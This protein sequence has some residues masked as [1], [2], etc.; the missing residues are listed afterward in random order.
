[1]LPLLAAPPAGTGMNPARLEKIRTRMQEFADRGKA[2][3]YVTLIERHGLIATLD[4]VGYQDLESKTPMRTDTIFQMMSMTKSLTCAGILI[5]M[6]EGRL[7]VVDAVEKHLPEFQGQR[8]EVCPQGA[9]CELLKP[10]RPIRI[11]DLMTHTSGMPG[12]APPEIGDTHHMTLAEAVSAYAKLPLGFEAGAKWRYSNTGIATLGRIIEVVSGI[13]YEKFIAQRI[14][15]P[16]G[17]QDSFYFPPADKRSRIAA[18]Y[19]EEN[20]KLKRAAGDIYREG[21]K[22]PMPEGG[23]YS[24]AS[25]M[26]AYYQM[27]LSGGAS[28]GGRVLSKYSV[29]LMTQVETGDL[30]VTFAPGLGYGYGLGVVKDPPGMFRLSSLGSFGHGGAYRTY[31]WVDPAKDM[32]SVI[33]LQRTNGGGDVADEINAFLAMAAAA[34]ER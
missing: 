17:M 15:K 5:L 31:G 22:Y 10:A 25:D 12:G 7:S 30:S 16:L 1:M 18:V 32:V 28:K 24:S 11:S 27:L 29:Q 4:A 8:V 2:A 23:L 21:W 3:G 20:G 13:P 33:L 14:L 19:T 6:E 26:A 9:P 34:I